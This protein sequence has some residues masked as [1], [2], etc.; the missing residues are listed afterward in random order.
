MRHVRAI[1]LW[2]QDLANTGELHLNKVK[3]EKQA[4]LFT[5]QLSAKGAEQHVG[6]ATD[7][8]GGGGRGPSQKCL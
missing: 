3:G 7:V 5:K 8:K 1:D 6:Q 4:D 2:I